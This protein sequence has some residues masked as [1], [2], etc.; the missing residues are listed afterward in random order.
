MI[1]I[2]SDTLIP[3]EHHFRVSAGPGA[4]K[5]H[6][7]VEHIKNVLYRSTRL[8]KTRKVACITYT[9]IGVETILTRLNTTINQVEVSTIHSFLYKH[10]VKPYAIFLV[11]DYGVNVESMDGHDDIIL[12]NY[13]FLK[14]WKN[15]TQ[16]Q[17]FKEDKLIV[18]AFN[19][20][21]W[22]FDDLG[23]LVAK[24]DYPRKIGKYPIKND[25]YYEY[26][27]MCW[28]RGI[29]HHDDVLFFSY[30]LIE[31]YPFILQ[32]LQSKFPYFFVDEF[33]D[34]NPIQVKIMELIGEKETIVGIIGDKA[35]SIYSF[36]G[37]E[38]FQFHSFNLNNMVDYIM[39]DNRRSTN[40]IID[41]LNTVRVDI[42]QNKFR[43][44]NGDKPI[45]IVGERLDALRI[46]KEKSNNEPVNSLSRKNIIS[47]AMKKEIM[48]DLFN[49]KLIEAL[50]NEDTP[51]SSNKYRSKVIIACIKATEFARQNEFK[52][53]LK[54]LE[55]I[56]K[57]KNDK[58][59][60]RKEALK[61]L[62]VLLS[63]YE[64]F[65]EKTLIE[66]H[67]FVKS[68]IKPDISNLSRGAAKT[69][70]DSHSYQ[71]L[72]LCVRID[73]DTSRHK[74]IHKAKGD[75]FKN[76]LVVLQEESDIEFL[77][78]PNLNDNNKE[79]QRI[80]YVA[81]SRATDRLFINVPT[82]TE[83]DSKKLGLLFDI[84]RT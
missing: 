4:G 40:Q 76:V 60:G 1:P 11:D 5:T 36:Q 77:L 28:E 81:I 79:E 55:R 68:N 22:K 48:G 7:L 35:Q 75:E 27:K 63:K 57:D 72:A 43:N 50:L 78:N 18:E 10:I 65:K 34:T 66:F 24:P 25:S 19:S 33:Q 54:E 38:P 59:K 39:A 29:I 74:T 30:Q 46:A 2:S 51:S 64:D 16:Q 56:F 23:T 26:K 84:I 42:K 52:S 71:Q 6:W 44:I 9:N 17:R 47:N 20:I 67:S 14:E 62:C 37:A 58:D 61:N 21:K 69:F 3:I 45:I 80:N 8:E 83:I 49:N 70:Y 41:I 73:E 53:A 13:S 31:K 82:L 12:S 32:V 15:R